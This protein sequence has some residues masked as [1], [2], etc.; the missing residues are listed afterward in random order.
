MSERHDTIQALLKRLAAEYAG[1]PNIQTVGFGLRDRGG[2]LQAERAIIFF[3]R[4]KYGTARQIEA[5]GSKVVPAEIEGFPTDV[6]PFNPRRATAGDRDEKEFDPLLGGVMTSNAEGHIYWF[7]GAGTLGCLVRDAGDGTP[8]ALSNWH[9]WG[10]GGEEGDDIIQPGHPTAGDHVEGV[11]KVA[12]CGPLVTSLL[13]WEAPDPLTV[14]LYGGA[15]AAAIA[16][17]ASDVRDPTRR[18]QDNTPPDPGELTTSESVVMA[19]EYPQVPV[20]G[21]PFETKV[22]WQYERM[23]TKGTRTFEIEETRVN[24][25]FLLGK[26]VVTD[27]PSYQPGEFVTLTAAIWDYQPRPCDGYHVVAHLIPHARPTT[28]LR[29]LLHPTTCP[30]R[31]P[32]DPPE[33][34]DGEVVCL[35]FDDF[36]P[37]T[38]PPKGAFAWLNYLS[39]GNDPV[40]IVNWFQPEQA[41]QIPSR[42]LLLTHAP[43]TRVIARVA[44]FTT[45]PVTLLAYNGAGQ[46][47]DEKAAP[48]SQG[49]A[50]ELVLSGA[51]IVRVV[52]RGGG[53]EGL[54]ISYCI[55]PVREG[56]ILTT[57]TPRIAAMMRMELPKLEMAASQLRARRCCFRG[58]IQLPPDEP[59]GKWDVHLT[60][61]NIND[62]PA[63]TPPDVAAT[64]IGGHVLSAHTSAE[65][66]GCTVVMLLDH[67]FDVI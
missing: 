21:V 30:R 63:G 58:R 59:A 28:A 43:A 62:V 18:G 23:T 44:Q 40:R 60:V 9:V 13:E 46:L 50:H 55:D 57:V 41:V 67:A 16:A 36:K 34:G 47:L 19:I 6:Q 37:T 20:P 65:I 56:Q 2:Q 45:T 64:T 8:M 17:A 49:T 54:L 48:P 52:A 26:Y 42:G 1:D 39:L 4:R 35:D 31:F 25:Q 7:N 24:T 3:V 12:A 22:Q 66:L 27:K 51:G 32:Q 14:G 5:L 61:Q 53:G 10:D 29:V 38:Y 33:T 11:V 15:A